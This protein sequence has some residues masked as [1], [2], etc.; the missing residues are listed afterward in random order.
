MI[1][2]TRHHTFLQQLTRMALRAHK[3]AMVGLRHDR[4][5][6]VTHHVGSAY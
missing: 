4:A 6:P 3:W 5:T 1:Y 2:R